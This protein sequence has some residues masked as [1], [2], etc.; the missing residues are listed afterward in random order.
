[1]SLKKF[2][3]HA[4]HGVVNRTLRRM[5]HIHIGLMNHLGS[6]Y[7]NLTNRALIFQKRLKRQPTLASIL[8]RPSVRVEPEYM[9][10]E[11]NLAVT[12]ANHRL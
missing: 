8:R 11:S 5:I 4:L 2:Q 1:M 6:L 7:Y 9:K 3:E 12:P 10:E